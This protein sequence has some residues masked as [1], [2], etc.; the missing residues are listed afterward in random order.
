M[1]TT[2]HGIIFYTDNTACSVELQSGTY[3][4]ESCFDDLA[5]AISGALGDNSVS[6][7]T[8]HSMVVKTFPASGGLTAN[9]GVNK[10]MSEADQKIIFDSFKITE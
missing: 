5:I 6:K 7:L 2:S 9:V 4:D 3:K 1:K 10:T 8:N